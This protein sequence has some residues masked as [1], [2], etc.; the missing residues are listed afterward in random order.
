MREVS[1]NPQK[2]LP[3]SLDD[4][5][6]NFDMSGLPFD[7]EL[8]DEYV[9]SEE[10][11]V[12]NWNK[13]MSELNVELYFRINFF[14]NEGDEHSVEMEYVNYLPYNLLEDDTE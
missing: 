6:H 13:E 8:E 11:E 4:F 12:S 9:A 2:T 5:V 7:A 1:L 10:P 3:G 14:K